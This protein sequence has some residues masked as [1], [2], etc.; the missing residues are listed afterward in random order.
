MTQIAVI[1]VSEIEK[2][3][4]AIAGSK[5]FGISS[6]EQAMALMLIAQA[7]GTHPALAARDYHIISNKPALKADAM[8]AR[9]Q[10]AG[11]KVDWQELTDT[12]VSAVFSHPSGGSA[13]IDWDMKRAEKAQLG[14][15]GM[16][17]KYPRQML[18]ARVISEG[19][20]TVFPGVVIGVYTP[21]EVQDFDNE[22][23]AMKDVTPAT[24]TPAIEYITQE[25]AIQIDLDLEEA[26]I[27]RIQFLEW[28]KAY[29]FDS[30]V[31]DDNNLVETKAHDTRLI[32]AKNL[33]KIEQVIRERKAE[34]KK[35]VAA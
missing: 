23:P 25:Q 8:L 20:R 26:G 13:L 10:S 14:A 30:Q 31:D 2:M 9:F 18:R 15:N 3:A 34:N 28:A 19:I 33:K 27:D 32:L 7:E 24:E 4:I 17:K 6:V 1:P 35:G 12:R 21:E 29:T 11:G 16:W 5:L 22:K